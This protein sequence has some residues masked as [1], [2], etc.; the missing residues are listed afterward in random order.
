M[1]HLT[2][3]EDIVSEINTLPLDDRHESLRIAGVVGEAADVAYQARVRAALARLEPRTTDEVI[4][5]R[6]ESGINVHRWI[7]LRRSARVSAS[8]EEFQTFARVLGVSARWLAIGAG[9]PEQPPTG[10]SAFGEHADQAATPLEFSD[11][12][13][14]DLLPL[15]ERPR[16]EVLT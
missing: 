10:W 6:R 8:P 2:Q 11:T 12:L 3:K 13:G 5:R 1:N 16:V 9:T 7:A 15:W 14:H 4:V